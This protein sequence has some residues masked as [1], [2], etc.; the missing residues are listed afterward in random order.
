MK[1]FEHSWRRRVLNILALLLDIIP[2]PLV[3]ASTVGS[4][5]DDVHAEPAAASSVQDNATSIHG[6]TTLE[7][8]VFRDHTPPN[9]AD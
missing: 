6:A 8:S 7:L 4:D 9:L 5:V 3:E 1:E 2:S